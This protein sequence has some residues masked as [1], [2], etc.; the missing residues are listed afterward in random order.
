[1]TR[2]TGRRKRRVPN[3]HQC[4]LTNCRAHAFVVPRGIAFIRTYIIKLFYANDWWVKINFDDIFWNQLRRLPLRWRE[5]IISYHYIIISVH[6]DYLDSKFSSKRSNIIG[7]TI[8]YF[9]YLFYSLYE[10][11]F[12][13]GEKSCTKN[14]VRYYF[15]FVIRS[16]RSFFDSVSIIVSPSETSGFKKTKKKLSNFF[17]K[18]FVFVRKYYHKLSDFVMSV[19]KRLCTV[20]SLIF[21]YYI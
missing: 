9:R 12:T 17:N 19:P 7:F 18:P 8:T 16:N 3:R 11:A 6:V 14:V 2:R 5:F 4:D 15:D 10:Y 13:S 21:F 1:M 20:I